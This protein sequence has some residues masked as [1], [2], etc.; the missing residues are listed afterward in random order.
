M[1]VKKQ[2]KNKNIPNL[3]IG[4]F[5]TNSVDLFFFFSDEGLIYRTRGGS[6]II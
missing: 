3:E 5:L 4:I 6:H 2:K 1:K